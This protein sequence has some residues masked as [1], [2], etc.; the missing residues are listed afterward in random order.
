[1]EEDIAGFD[2]SRALQPT[3]GDF[4]ILE[5]LRRLAFTE[6]VCRPEKI[7]MNMD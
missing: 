4:E 1:M 7:A 5:N 3:S 2:L 6:Q